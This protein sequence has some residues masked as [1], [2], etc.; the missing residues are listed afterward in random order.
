MF[1]VPPAPTDKEFAPVLSRIQQ[2]ELESAT[3]DVQKGRA[4]AADD[5]QTQS[6]TRGLV[7]F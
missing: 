7:I 5:R 1:A 6:N 3:D 2:S 4:T